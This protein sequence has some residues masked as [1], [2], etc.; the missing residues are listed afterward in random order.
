MHSY[1]LEA[2]GIQVKPEMIAQL[3]FDV[4]TCSFSS[5]RSSLA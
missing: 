2:R 4:G 3:T 5:V 1:D